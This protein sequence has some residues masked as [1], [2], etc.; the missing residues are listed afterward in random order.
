[1]P[2]LGIIASSLLAAAGDYESIATVSVGSGGA[3]NVEFTSIP[4]TYS[5][6]QIRGMAKD[7]NSTTQQLRLQINTDTG[8]NYAYHQLFGDGSSASAGAAASQALISIPYAV[9]LNNVTSVFGVTIVDILD[10]ANTNKY[11][12]VRSL[13]GTDVNGSDGVVGISS[14]LWQNTSA[15]TSIKFYLTGGANFAQYTTFA[16]YGIKGA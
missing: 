3:A 5:H 13:H 10:Y 7:S 12:T 16:L 15:I 6:L 1:M 2:I 11:K 4:A 14:G 9:A 8:N